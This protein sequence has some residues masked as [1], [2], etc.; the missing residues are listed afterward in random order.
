MWPNDKLTGMAAFFYWYLLGGIK[1]LT[2]GQ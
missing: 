2:P 1:Q